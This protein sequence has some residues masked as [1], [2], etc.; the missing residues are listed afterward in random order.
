MAIVFFASSELDTVYVQ[1]FMWSSLLTL[2]NKPV[3]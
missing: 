2:G 3:E 1:H